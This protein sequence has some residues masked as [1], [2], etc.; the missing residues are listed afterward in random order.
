MRLDIVHGERPMA[1]DQE[2]SAGHQTLLEIL[3]VAVASSADTVEMEYDS[4]GCLE[5]CFMSG[6][7]GAGYHLNREVAGKVIEALWQEKKK[8][9]GKK[10]RVTIDGKDYMVQVQTYDHFG[11]NAYRLIVCAAKR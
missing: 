3:T 8:S 4:G 2:K 6:N 1:E 9:R 11:E 10:F 5:V 7:S